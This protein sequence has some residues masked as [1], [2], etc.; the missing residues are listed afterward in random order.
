MGQ[1]EILTHIPIRFL[2]KLKVYLALFGHSANILHTDGKTSGCRPCNNSQNGRNAIHRV[3]PKKVNKVITT[4]VIRPL[5]N[6]T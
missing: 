1:I 4:M 5:D 2:Y 3:S 6:P